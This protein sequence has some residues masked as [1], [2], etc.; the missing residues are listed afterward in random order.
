MEAKN[1]D[2][3]LFQLHN[4]L[5]RIGVDAEE[6]IFADFEEHFKAGLEQGISEEETCRRLGDVKE[7]ARSYI[8]I[9]DSRLNSIVA[10]AIEEN[11]PHVSLTKPGRDVPADLSLMKN[12]PEADA[13]AQHPIREYTPQHISDE[14]IPN[15]AGSA[16]GMTADNAHTVREYTPE[17][18]TDESAPSSPSGS[19]PPLNK[20][21]ADNEA[22]P[23]ATPARE[24]TPDHIA[25][26][27]AP[28]SSAAQT[29]AGG[30]YSVPQPQSTH[31]QNYSSDRKSEI[32]PQTC[33]PVGSG[34]GFKF[35]DLKGLTPNVNIGKLITMI[36]LDI[37]IFS[38]A[39]PALASLIMGFIAATLGCFASGMGAMSY[40][41]FHILSRIFLQIGIV[42]LSVLM[43]LLAIKMVIGFCKIIRSIIVSHV[44]AI[45]DL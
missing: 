10:H 25:P 41:E 18:I 30:A 38:W 43:A 12:K 20:P 4:E 7:I 6:E 22:A 17:H 11:K 28:P 32:P 21:A 15:A 42:S 44:K 24:F 34:K 29:N 1:K 13:P 36:A 39:L 2:D 35:K 3:F 19:H 40:E 9:D 31:Q 33:P 5:H 27:T 26:E 37:F 8:D 16:N 45:F 23:A 14:V